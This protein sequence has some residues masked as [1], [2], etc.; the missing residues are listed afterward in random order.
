M[1]KPVIAQLLSTFRTGGAETFAVE[2]ATCMQDGPF[3]P[4]AIALKQAG[5]IQQ[6]FLDAGIDARMAHCG[7]GRGLHLR[8]ISRLARLL[9]SEKIQVLHCHNRGA[10]IYGALAAKLAGVPVT[11]CTRHAAPPTFRKGKPRLVLLE[12]LVRPLTTYFIAVSDFVMHTAVRVGRLPGSRVCVIRNGIDTG[13]YTPAP[14]RHTDAPT[15]ICVARLSREKRHLM[16]LSAAHRLMNDGL[17]FRLRI[18]GDGPMRQHIAQRTETLALQSVIE[19]L[20]E[21]NDVP[22][23]LRQA[24]VFVLSSAT[25]GL[26]MTI[27]E[28]MACG[29]PVVAT[30]VG[31]VPELVV[32]GANGLL[33]PPED[34]EA[35]AGALRKLIEN[36]QLRRTMGAAGRKLAVEQFDIRQTARQHEQLFTRLLQQ[37]GIHALPRPE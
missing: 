22:H 30:R 29:L 24:D 15:L 8:G 31:G 2:L 16:L 36:A 13:R 5:P 33:V 17:R 21:R 12:R 1:H 35:L 3:R 23:L 9:R 6:R 18:V 7:T 19:M 4:I 25:E 20:G 37:K 28:A 27:I 26:P 11:V 14:P 34:T 32:S 10:N